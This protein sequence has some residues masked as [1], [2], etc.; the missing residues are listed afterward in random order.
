MASVLAYTGL[1]GEVLDYHEYHD[2][3]A[4]AFY[5]GDLVKY[6]TNGEVQIATAGVMS[7]I[8][9]K[10]ALGVDQ[11]VIPVDILNINTI[12]VGKHTTTATAES[13]IGD[14]LDF[15]FTAGGH[16]LAIGG[17]TDV[18]CVG[19]HPDDG[20]LAGGRLLI[21]FLYTQFTGLAD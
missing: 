14:I 6:N 7:G 1:S 3:G 20:A 5:K 19:L 16:T 21:R 11:T 17:T 10:T 12:Y 4:N 15:T 8:A 2:S 13:M 18:Y 9:K